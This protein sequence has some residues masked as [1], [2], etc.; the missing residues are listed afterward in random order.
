MTG[1]FDNP[2]A[3]ATARFDVADQQADTINN[4]GRDQYLQQIVIAREDAYRR[5]EPMN[6]A[7]SVL[8]S[9]GFGLAGVGV[10]SFIG[11]GAAGA[12]ANDGALIVVAGVPVIAIAM[13]VALT[14]IALCIV[15]MVASGLVSRRR[16]HID[17]RYPMTLEG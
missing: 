5:L 11:S 8:F 3:R 13:A 1:H 15:A 2:E 6:R 7:V 14:G 17:R 12:I 9:L 16:R 10:L 4:V